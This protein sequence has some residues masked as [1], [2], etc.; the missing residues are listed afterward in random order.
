[1]SRSEGYDP[2]YDRDEYSRMAHEEHEAD[3]PHWMAKGS[4][5][6]TVYPFDPRLGKSIETPLWIPFDWTYL[7]VTP[8][9]SRE[10]VI[11][12]LRDNLS[13]AV[14]HAADLIL[15]IDLEVCEIEDLDITWEV[16]G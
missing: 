5:K 13:L 6:I 9:D 15:H 8:D 2:E 11:E 16:D 14:K 4:I 7:D 3:P 1:M 12:N 10:D